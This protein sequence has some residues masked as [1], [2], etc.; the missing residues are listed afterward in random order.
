MSKATKI[1]IIVLA[2]L[3]LFLLGALVV[4][5]NSDFPSVYMKGEQVGVY[6]GDC[7]ILNGDLTEEEAHVVL[8]NLFKQ[9]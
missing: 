3:Y 4:K 1:T 8:S 2:G 5:E 6:V 9:K 7:Y